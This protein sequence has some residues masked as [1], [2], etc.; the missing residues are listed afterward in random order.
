M[1]SDDRFIL[2]MIG[3]VYIVP[4]ALLMLVMIVVALASGG[5]WVSFFK[6]VALY[7]LVV[8]AGLMATAVVSAT[9]YGLGLAVEHLTGSVPLGWATFAVVVFLEVSL[10]VGA[11]FKLVR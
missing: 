7:W 11:L 4:F 5:C 10:I 9:S 6:V 1:D 8:V 2:W 3:L